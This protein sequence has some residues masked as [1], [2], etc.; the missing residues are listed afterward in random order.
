MT[1]Y[2]CLIAHFTNLQQFTVCKIFILPG[3]QIDIAFVFEHLYGQV[4]VNAKKYKHIKEKT[5]FI[6]K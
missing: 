4:D 1:H 2:F 3:I 6:Q 5:Q